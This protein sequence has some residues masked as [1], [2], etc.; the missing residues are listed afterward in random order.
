MAN[1]PFFFGHKP[2]T[3]SLAPLLCDFGGY[4][5]NIKNY[6]KKYKIVNIF[7]LVLDYR[8]WSLL[9]KSSRAIPATSFDLLKRRLLKEW[10]EIDQKT[11]RASVEVFLADFGQ[12]FGQKAIILNK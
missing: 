4:K 8:V 1:W 9:E 11:L 10:A 6:I 12:L 3:K 2:R 7:S 5:F